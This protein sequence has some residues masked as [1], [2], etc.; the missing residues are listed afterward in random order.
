MGAAAALAD[1]DCPYSTWAAV[2]V[3]AAV[4]A[5]VELSLTSETWEHL[6]VVVAVVDLTWADFVG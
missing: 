1:F 4:V 2:V 3:V 5:V 6:Q